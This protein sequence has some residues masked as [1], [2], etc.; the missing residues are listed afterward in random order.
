MEPNEHEMRS[1]ATQ[2]LKYRWLDLVRSKN[3]P[4]PTIRHLL[5]T[6][7]SHME[8]DG[9]NCFPGVRRLE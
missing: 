5:V 3:G 2:P 6:L 8:V 9:A 7:G 1:E 4:H